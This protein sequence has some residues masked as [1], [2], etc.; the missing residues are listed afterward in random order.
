M[1]RR[2]RTRN[3][4]TARREKLHAGRDEIGTASCRHAIPPRRT[5]A[6]RTSASG[7]TAAPAT[8]NGET[9][10]ADAG[11]E[12]QDDEDAIVEGPIFA[13]VDKNMIAALAKGATE[14][15]LPPGV[16]LGSGSNWEK[17]EA[18]LLT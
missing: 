1:P 2:T 15:V 14:A 11:V 10:E 12:E 3:C 6:R 8:V 7:R 5:S 17:K 16:E 13:R 9:P 18:K 4:A